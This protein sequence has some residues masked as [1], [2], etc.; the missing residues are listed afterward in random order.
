MF[1]EN[2]KYV[3]LS[4]IAVAIIIVA[5]FIIGRITYSFVTPQIDEW[6]NAQGEVTAT[7]NTLLF[8]KGNDLGVDISTD[9]F[10][11]SSG[12]LVSTTNP[13]ARLIPGDATE[14]AE[15][16]YNIGFYI[17]NNTYQYSQVGNAELILY[18][19]DE[20]SEITSITNGEDTINK[21]SI[22]DP[23][24]NSKTISGFDITGRTGLFIVDDNHA[25]SS[26]VKAGTTQEWTFKLIFVNYSYDQSINEDAEASIQ[27]IMQQDTLDICNI[28][29]DTLGCIPT[30][31]FNVNGGDEL[32][33]SAIKLDVLE[34]LPTPTKDGYTFLGWYTEEIDGT[35]ISDVADLEEVTLNTTLYAHWEEYPYTLMYS[36]TSPTTYSGGTYEDTTWYVN[37]DKD[38]EII[39][40]FSVTSVSSRNLIIGNYNCTNEL[41][42]E[43]Y[44]SSIRMYSNG[45]FGSYTGTLES[46]KETEMRISY[47]AATDV[48]TAIATWN[49]GASTASNTGTKSN[50]GKSAYPLR[51]GQDRRGGSTFSTI[52]VNSVYIYEHK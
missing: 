50:S 4:I 8:I 42:I 52:T 35:L 26:N 40:N 34:E 47:N 12:N 30:I 23:N 38:F 37:W 11:S 6:E 25:I 49:N 15:E 13:K 28:K 17:E 9:N 32:D 39:I 1:K 5:A 43:L 27:I 22:T 45:D 18:I 7:G 21:I 36:K 48:M 3:I 31:T 19:E 10:N 16:T 51:L 44:S 46:N 20:E 29:P 14:G 24:D 33:E 41:N 2:K